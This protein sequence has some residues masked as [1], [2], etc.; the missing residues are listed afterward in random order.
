MKNWFKN[1]LLVGSLVL[2]A[3]SFGQ[4]EV[5]IDT[6]I[7]HV[8][9]IDA[10]RI[11][12]SIVIIAPPPLTGL[13]KDDIEV[14]NPDD[15]AGL[16]SKVPG[17]TIRSY[18]GLGGLKTV[19][20]RGLGGQH[21]AV[22]IDGFEVTN[23]QAGQMNLGQLQAEGLERITSGLLLP[24]QNLQP[25]SS[26]FAGNNLLFSTF[27]DRSNS[28]RFRMKS[29]V[30]YGS[31]MR[32]EVYAQGEKS[33][34]HWNFGAFGKYRDANGAYPYE[35]LNGATQT[36]GLRGN[37]DFQD[38]HFG[39]KVGRTFGE[40]QNKRIRVMYRSSLID[41]GLPG[42]VIL[43]NESADERMKTQDHRILVDYS[44]YKYHSNYRTYL[45]LGTNEME[46]S[47]PTYLNAEGFVL[48]QF[49]NF[50]ADGGYVHYKELQRF[51]LK[52]GAEEKVEILRSNRK[53]FGQP[54]RASTFGLVG[55]QKELEK[56]YFE[57]IAGGQFVHDQNAEGNNQHIQFTPNA[58]VRYKLSKQRR[59]STELLY[60]RNFRLPSFN[61]LYF[62]EVGNSN[63]KPEIAHQMN[64]GLDWKIKE[65][66]YGWHWGVHAQGYYNRV[67]NKIVAI[68]TKNLFIW[69][70]Q[71]V[72]EAAIYGATGET[73]IVHRFRNETRIELMA[74]YT[75]QRVIDITPDAITYG[76]QVAYAPEHTA[77]GDAM[78][79]YKG[80]SLRVSNNFV[81]GRY[82]LNQN[83]PAN[84]LDP[85]WT[86]DLALG[87]K[88]TIHG[89]H[90]VGVQLNVRNLTD[91]SYAFIRSYVMPGRH[92]LL[93]LNYEIF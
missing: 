65:R 93:T 32:R 67:H 20:M 46:Y 48:D 61:E 84:Y 19:S 53:D 56:W 69:S 33:L 62:G 76:D 8:K 23:A 24:F 21:T 50:Q 92:Y 27:L 66:Y 59:I 49:R 10:V 12:L 5:E 6:S 30:R 71:N 79:L 35:F 51:K 86:M 75:W 22:I 3:F 88:Y 28:S 2:P 74:N 52:W 44:S 14:L 91:V 80:A 57:A 15:V 72:A 90:K 83:V 47:D 13:N 54:L 11:P 58:F 68:P 16:V 73:R 70:M 42:A 89:K 78:F 63:L 9:H 41:Q 43:Y 17:A 40:Y 36:A 77:N 18:G 81:S 26:N 87:Y 29:S 82:A 85:F 31:F 37:N 38:M 4:E 45:N 39:A 55:A 60:K 34:N 7:T 25:V 1:S 64:L